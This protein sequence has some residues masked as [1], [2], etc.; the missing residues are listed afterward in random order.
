MLLLLPGWSLPTACG[1]AAI[2][3]ML[4]YFGV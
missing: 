3:L 2:K 4:H 1:V